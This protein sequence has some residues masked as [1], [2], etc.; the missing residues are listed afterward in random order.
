MA[1]TVSWQNAVPV[2][3]VSEAVAQTEEKYWKWVYGEPPFFF[4][5]LFLYLQNTVLAGWTCLLVTT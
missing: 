3:H 1:Y 4:F 2:V 5:F